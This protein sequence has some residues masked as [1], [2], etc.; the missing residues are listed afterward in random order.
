VRSVIYMDVTSG[1]P[2]QSVY[3][4][5]NINNNQE[6]KPGRTSKSSS[7][8]L[9][10]MLCLS[11]PRK[12]ITNIR[13]ESLPCSIDKELASQNVTILAKIGFQKAVN[14]HCIKILPLLPFSLIFFL[15]ARHI[16]KFAYTIREEQ[17]ARIGV[18]H[19][20]R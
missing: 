18:T 2:C 6:R 4:K 8:C 3:I 10:L 15:Y 12:G 5:G 17:L 11:I 20:R 16:H 1:R 7:S 13:T 19:Q 9:S 14:E